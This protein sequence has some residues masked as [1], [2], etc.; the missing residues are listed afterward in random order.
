MMLAA[1]WFLFGSSLTMAIALQFG[2]M[3]ADYHSLSCNVRFM[4]TCDGV[5][6]RAQPGTRMVARYG[7]AWRPYARRAP[8]LSARGLG[9]ADVVP[10]SGLDSL[11]EKLPGLYCYSRPG[12]RYAIGVHHAW[13]ISVTA[14]MY[15]FARWSIRR[16]AR[17][18]SLSP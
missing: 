13:L 1:L 17:I 10:A 14:S 3:T 18:K 8:E 7:Y 2:F 5:T 11:A 15:L 4:A 16:S 12:N 6:L 9:D